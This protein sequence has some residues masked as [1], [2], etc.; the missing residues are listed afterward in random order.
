MASTASLKITP[1]STLAPD[2][3]D[4][5]AAGED[6]AGD[7][8]FP[9]QEDM[10]QLQEQQQETDEERERHIKFMR[11]QVALNRQIERF[12]RMLTYDHMK[13]TMLWFLDVATVRFSFTFED[14]TL[15]MT[16]FVLFGD[17]IKI[18]CV[19]STDG[20]F[21]HFLHYFVSLFNFVFRCD[22]VLFFFI[23]LII[24]SRRWCICHGLCSLSVHLY[25]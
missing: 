6:G 25:L 14:V 8:N 9:T 22:F 21:T 16:L 17:D 7:R 5:Q 2:I 3:E 1:I 23:S 19:S 12:E 20:K 18:L 15:L 13:K 10:E 11:R 4:P 24:S